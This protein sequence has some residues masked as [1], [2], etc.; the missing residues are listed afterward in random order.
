MTEQT[1]RPYSK[2]GTQRLMRF[3]NVPMRLALRLPV[4]TPLN[5]QLMLLA[6]TGRKSG[7][8][9]KQ[10]VSYIPDDGTLLTPGGG[11][12]KLNLRDDRS[13]DVWLRGQK[14]M[15]RPEFV[16]DP[17][18]VERLLKKMAAANPRVASFV[19]VIGS[20]GEIDRDKLENAIGYGFCV[21]R[22]HLEGAKSH[23]LI[24]AMQGS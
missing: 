9:Y 20:D 18:E 2:P 22:W 8:A 23:Q 19:P 7:K 3:V 5:K 14:V 16:R 24:R 6:F 10:P 15:A 4:P 13:I 17:D 12:W 1:Q 11:K 21:I